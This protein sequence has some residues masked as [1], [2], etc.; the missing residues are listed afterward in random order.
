MLHPAD[1]PETAKAFYHAIQTGT[2]YQAVHR[3]RRA[4]GEFR[5]HHTRGEPLRDREGRIVQ[6]YGLSVD[7]DE[8][9][10]GRRPAT[11][12]RSL[13]RGS[14]E[15][16]SHRCVGLQRIENSLL[17][18]GDLSIWG[19]DPTQG[20]PSREAVLQRIHPDDREQDARGGLS[21]RSTRKKATRSSSELYCPTEQS[22]TSNQSADPMFSASGE[23][24]EVVAAHADV[25]ER[26]RAEELLRRS[27]AHL[28]EAQGSVTPVQ[29]YTTGRRFSMGRRRLIASGD[30]IRRRVFRAAMSLLPTDPPG[31]PRPAERRGSARSGRE[32]RLLARVQNRNARGNGQTTWNLI[33]QPCSPR[34]GNL[35]RFS[36]HRST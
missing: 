10:E 14:T 16:E 35:S 2:S 1:F 25:T 4:D 27:E 7:I 28:A 8:A 20:I 11:P 30:L 15:A 12:Q 6:W 26:K 13:S 31:R 21:E 22:N 5:W 9:Q 19:F 3:L 36:L 17:V 32:K 18:G 23:L 34:A 33:G 24:V 29:W